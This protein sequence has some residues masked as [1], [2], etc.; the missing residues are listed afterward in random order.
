MKN[1][2]NKTSGSRELK[3]PYTLNRN[4]IE[5]AP[6]ALLLAATVILTVV[7]ISVMVM[8]FKAS[9]E[10]MNVTSEQIS[11]RTEEIRNGELLELDGMVVDGADVL[12]V[13]KKQL[14][15]GMKVT[16]KNGSVSKTYS[17]ASDV[18]KLRDY[19]STEYIKPF[20]TWKCSVLKNKNG[21][22]TEII[23]NK[24]EI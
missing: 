18:A 6:R 1:N 19:E 24:K 3:Q 16:L 15:K 10:M 2:Q 11:E 14:G 21:I 20:T 12:N 8:Q 7:L 17:D 22:I 5:I 13:C 23:F 4:C 9:K